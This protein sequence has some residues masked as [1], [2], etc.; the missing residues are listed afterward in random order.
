MVLIG[1]GQRGARTLAN[2][3]LR[4]PEEMRLV[5]VAEPNE[6]RRNWIAQAHQI[7]SKRCFHSWEDLLA[8]PL[9]ADMVIVAHPDEL[10]AQ[11]TIHALQAGY[12]ALVTS[13]LAPQMIDCLEM[14]ETATATDKHLI[15]NHSLRYTAFYRALHDI[16]KTGRLGRIIN[17]R[18]ERRLP[19]WYTAHQFI[20]QPHTPRLQNPILFADGI[21][22][23][24][25]LLWLLRENMTHVSSVGTLRP[26]TPAQAPL[27]NIPPRCLDECPLEAECPYSAIGAYLEKRFA[28]MP[29]QGFPYTTLADGDESESSILQQVEN[30]N[31]GAC[32]YHQHQELID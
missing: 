6:T 20:R 8:A 27:A 19:F 9:M 17:Y 25:L 7:P 18:Q 32:V 3:A 22:E 11:T 13:P 1:A 5:A 29:Q 30:G 31:W 21:H 14:V 16:L 15:L 4:R 10:H 26:F 2:F 24:D 23:F 12:H 28:G